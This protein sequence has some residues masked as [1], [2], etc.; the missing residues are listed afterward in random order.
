MALGSLGVCM[1]NMNGPVLL[2]GFT[3][4]KPRGPIH[5]LGFVKP[6]EKNGAVSSYRPFMW[7]ESLL[8]YN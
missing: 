3:E 4:H 1:A 7:P 2:A 6:L 8:E 5:L